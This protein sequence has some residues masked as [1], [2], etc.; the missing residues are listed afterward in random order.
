M[1]IQW[2]PASHSHGTV[3]LQQLKK[4]LDHGPGFIGAISD[5]DALSAVE[6]IAATVP[7]DDSILLLGI[8]GS[9]LGARALAAALAPEPI[10]DLNILDNIDP[11][12][13]ERKLSRLDLSRTTVLVI[14]KSGATAETSAQLL[15]IIAALRAAGVDPDQKI[16]AITDR[17]KGPLRALASKCGWRTLEVPSDVGGRF[18]V[19]TAV[20]W[21]PAILVGID[22]RK[23]TQGARNCLKDLQ[24]ADENH[25]LVQSASEWARCSA[26]HKTV[27]LF[28][29]RDRL[30]T[31]GDWFAQLWAESLGKR[32][33]LAG[34]EVWNGSTPIVAR[35]VTDQH[36]LV[37][38]FVEGPDDKQY[39]FLDAP[40]EGSDP[41]I[42]SDLA[43]LHPDFG[44]L[45]G[46]SLDQLRIAEWEGTIAALRAAGRPV[47]T[48]QLEK[49][50]EAHLGALMLLWEMM[51]LLA[52]A[53]LNVD[54]F[55]QPGVEA[56]KAV[57]FA[58]MGRE[59]WQEKADAIT[60]GASSPPPAPA[61][62]C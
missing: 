60:A 61:I 24:Q 29:Y 23:L 11:D 12:T 8:G 2:T 45:S 41:V 53:E 39:V 51:T 20:G 37:Q 54:P 46:K 43:D 33:D 16:I 44:Y 59:G 27:V 49:L 34:N 6:Q 32:L 31:F 30:R 22:I 3:Q 4:I 42:E 9:A 26:S 21:L 15:R 7:A 25:A 36:S 56:G 48:I 50:D 14:S 62:D 28:P 47:S 18:S 52:A 58:K 35:G 1:S 17:Q 19:M 13:V 57:A 38:L 5:D 10:R 40:L 55:D